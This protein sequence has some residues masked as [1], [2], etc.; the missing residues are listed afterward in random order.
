MKSPSLL[1]SIAAAVAMTFGFSTSAAQGQG[2][3]GGADTN[4]DG[5]VNGVDLAVVLGAWGVCPGTITSVT[6][7]QGSI[8]GGTQITINGTNLTG[9]TA[10]KIGGV[11]CTSLQVLSPTLVKAVTPAGT[12]GEFALTIITAA[13]TLF[14]PTPF[15]YVQL[16]IA[17]VSPNQ[18]IFSGGTATT[19]VA[20]TPP[21]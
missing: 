4:G 12:A 15:T 2:S 21:T 8:L 6:P 10:V 3:C 19:F 14:S 11:D 16:S 20:G 9:T 5:L 13:G 7:L 1:L 18:G 17:S